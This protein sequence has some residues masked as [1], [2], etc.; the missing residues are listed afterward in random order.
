MPASVIFPLWSSASA[1]ARF[2]LLQGLPGRRGVN[3]TEKSLRVH[4]LNAAVDPPVAQGF[5]QSVLV[6]DGLLPRGSFLEDQPDLRRSARVAGKPLRE[7]TGT[8]RV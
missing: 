3:R 2:R 6:R 4:G 1:N 5:L 8:L 7:I